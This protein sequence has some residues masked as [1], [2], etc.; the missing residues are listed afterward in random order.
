MF[1]ASK[2]FS[3]SSIIEAF[4]GSTH[5]EAF[6][7][8]ITFVGSIGVKTLACSS[9]IETFANEG[10]FAIASQIETFYV[11]AFASSEELDSSILFEVAVGSWLADDAAVDF[12]I[13]I[14]TREAKRP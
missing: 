5:V 9:C 12:S 3:S 14:E 7:H 2:T 10:T 8:P 6:T 11:K 4:V 1:V 13:S